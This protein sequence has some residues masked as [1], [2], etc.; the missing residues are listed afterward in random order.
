MPIQAGGGSRLRSALSR[1]RFLG[2]PNQDSEFHRTVEHVALTGID[3]DSSDE[4]YGDVPDRPSLSE[5]SSE[6]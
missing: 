1:P 2:R 5:G 6:E 3:D 4:G